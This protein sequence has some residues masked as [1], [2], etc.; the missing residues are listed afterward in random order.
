MMG[1]M[2]KEG[3]QR[4]GDAQEEQQGGELWGGCVT[5]EGDS[6]ALGFRD[7][8]RVRRAPLQLRQAG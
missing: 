4:W 3:A 8:L 6:N 2:A 5:G 7:M 1:D